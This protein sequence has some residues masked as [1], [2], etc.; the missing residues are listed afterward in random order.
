MIENLLSNFFFLGKCALY[1][2]GL[3]FI[4]NSILTVT[5]SKYQKLT[6][7][8]QLYVTKNISKSI[9]LS[10]VCIRLFWIG[11]D[12]YI[13]IPLD[14]TIVKNTA[15]IYV[16]NDIVALLIVPKLPLTTKRHH[17]TTT[18]LLFINYFINYEHLEFVSA[19]IGILLIGYTAFSAF[20]FMV[21]LFLGLRFI[22]DNLNLINK[23]RIIALYNYKICLLLNWISQAGFII[24][25]MIHD[26]STVIPF[27]IY[28][29]LL[30]PIIND[31]LVLVSWLNIPKKVTKSLNH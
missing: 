5:N 21:N 27:I 20:A 31:D 7:N 19:K 25:S 26:S 30:I 12:I 14:N 1:I 9:V 17:M 23:V 11:Y 24:N 8:K 28:S 4:V 6:Y 2:V 15:S 29:L 18:L 16:A 13:N 3:C 22:T 10:L